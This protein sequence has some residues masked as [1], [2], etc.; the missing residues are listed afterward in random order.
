MDPIVKLHPESSEQHCACAELCTK[1]KELKDERQ[2]TA[3]LDGKV[4]KLEGTVHQMTKSAQ[5]QAATAQE[6]RESASQAKTAADAAYQKVRH[7]VWTSSDVMCA[8]TLSS[9]FLGV[10]LVESGSS[11]TSDC[12]SA[13]S[14]NFPWIKPSH[15]KRHWRKQMPHSKSHRMVQLSWER[16]SNAL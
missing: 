16:N 5:E 1:E 8:I 11:G 2:K 4:K 14:F 13:H 12:R 15:S 3:K 9:K 10:Y 6:L 7:L